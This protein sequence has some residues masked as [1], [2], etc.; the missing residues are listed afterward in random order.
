MKKYL[1]TYF[2]NFDYP[3]F[4]TYLFLCLFGLV[5]IYS[6]SMMVAITE[7][8]P[9]DY[10]YLKQLTNLKIAALAFLAGHF[11]LTSITVIK[12]FFYTDECDGDFAPLG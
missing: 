4:F 11:F 12:A 1:V 10:Y 5:M 8:R 7:E 3:L 2:R 9:P 6:S